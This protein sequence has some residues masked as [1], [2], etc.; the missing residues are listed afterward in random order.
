MSHVKLLL[1]GPCFI[2]LG[3]MVIGLKYLGDEHMQLPF[4]PFDGI[5]AILGGIFITR[6]A[7]KTAFFSSPEETQETNV[8][9]APRQ[10]GPIVDSEPTE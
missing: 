7:V 8:D 4:W 6:F 2:F 3:I 1:A 5:L 10:T 9:D